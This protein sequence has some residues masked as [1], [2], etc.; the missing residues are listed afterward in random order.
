VAQGTLVGIV[1]RKDVLRAAHGE[2]YLDA[3]GV[4]PHIEATQAF[5]A[6]VLTL[7]PAEAREALHRLG[8][9]AE[10]MGVQVHV[11]GGFVRDMVLGR[12]SLDI[13][14]VVEGDGVE[15]GQRAAEEL[16]VRVRIHRRFGSA[17]L[18]FS[19]DLHVDIAS[20][21][22][23]YYSKPGALPTVER[24]GLR[25]DLF[26]RDFTINAMA[27]CIVPAAF[28]SIADPY[29][30]LDDLKRGRVRVLHAL[31]F[32]DDPTRILRAARFEVRY[33]FVLDPVSEHLATRA[34]A[35]E[36]LD[37]MLREDDPSAILARLDV[38][39]AAAA[40][41][42]EGSEPTSAAR[43]VGAAADAYAHLAGIGVRGASSRRRSLLA[44]L[45]ASGSQPGAERWIRHFRIGR[46]DALVIRAVAMSAGVSRALADGRRM[47]DSRLA[48]MLVSLPPEAIV[49]LWARGGEVARGRI[50]RFSGELA[51]V[52]PAVSGRDLIALGAEP[53]ETFS[54]IL[55]R[56]RD[57]RLDGRAVGR[58]AELANLK[59]LASHAGLIP[60][61]RTRA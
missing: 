49:N 40:L 8:D 58:E 14:L 38:L 37:D 15:F 26:R 21:R 39:G 29:A 45:A 5:L 18:V 20:S 17:V 57:D 31:S 43:A 11:V 51:A 50:E 46:D 47:K 35:L 22:A 59:R 13:D 27:A 28:G 54:A 42:P 19:R 48:G 32:I 24:S 60:T 44:A 36:E 30:G 3:S 16:G 33:G 2:A 53:G 55:A 56:A 10:R 25:Q 61:G 1:T 7:L 4:Q 9:L 23:E 41:V 34:T 6:G 52:R 12:P